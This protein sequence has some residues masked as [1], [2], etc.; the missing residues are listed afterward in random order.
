MK[1]FVYIKVAALQAE[2][3]LKYELC[4]WVFRGIGHNHT[5]MVITC[6]ILGIAISPIQ[7]RFILE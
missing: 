3:L 7:Q 6:I 5:K 1:G 2:K 4:T